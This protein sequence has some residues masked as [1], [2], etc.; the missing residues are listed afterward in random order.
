MNELL[1]CF[2]SDGVFL[3]YL[4]ICLKGENSSSAEMVKDKKY[5]KFKNVQIDPDEA[6]ID[7]LHKTFLE[8]F[9]EDG[10]SYV[11]EMKDGDHGFPA[12]VKYENEYAESA[13]I[14][15]E[16]AITFKGK[17]IY[18]NDKG[19]ASIRSCPKSIKQSCSSSD[20]NSQL[21]IGKPLVDECLQ[22]FV[23]HS[24]FGDKSKFPEYKPV[25]TTRYEAKK[26]NLI[27]PS[28]KFL[29]VIPSNIRVHTTTFQEFYTINFQ[30]GK[31][32]HKYNYHLKI[33]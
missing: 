17:G 28:Q 3:N 9:K 14:K 11:F 12:F 23:D 16:S 2:Y 21:E 31:S 13:K 32:T 1:Q 19:P 20:P 24:N 8:N 30:G 6:C 25:M 5:N 33:K 27:Q 4:F 22:T 7:P 18:G 29:A 15:S 26:E 10:N